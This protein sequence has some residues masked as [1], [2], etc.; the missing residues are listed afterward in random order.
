ML[1]LLLFVLDVLG[2]FL[3]V[4]LGLTLGVRCF[5]FLLFARRRLRELDSSEDLPF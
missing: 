4:V 2:P 1:N 3:A 5:R